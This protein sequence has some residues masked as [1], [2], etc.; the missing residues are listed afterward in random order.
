MASKMSKTAL[1]AVL[2]IFIASAVM[3][4]SMADQV[5]FTSTQVSY[6]AS[7]LPSL[8]LQQACKVA[9]AL[10]LGRHT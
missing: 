3:R 8:S 7:F 9:S 4:Y 10:R 6:E 1:A 5:F 2:I